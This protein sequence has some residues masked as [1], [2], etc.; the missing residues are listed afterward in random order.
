MN[1]A[2]IVFC[3]CFFLMGTGCAKIPTQEM[4]DA[5]QAIKAAHE[6]KA[7]L[8]VPEKLSEAE[9][10]LLDAENNLESGLIDDARQ[11]AIFAK[12]SALQARN[13]AS[14]IDHTETIWRAISV[15][16]YK[17]NSF[18][19]ILNKA[20]ELINQNNIEQALVL[21]E[22]THKEGKR[23]LNQIFLDRAKA[24]IEKARNQEM[25]LH[26]DELA[27]LK[28]AESAYARGDGDKSFNLIVLLFQ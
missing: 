15:M 20:K 6:A 28:N 21:I 4:S 2:R 3:L 23:V 12:D 9:K 17:V 1:I 16:D 14:A 7:E 27:I 25:F 8:Y 19:I 22:E 18:P 5:R 26:P 10:K 13:I 11:N 24:L